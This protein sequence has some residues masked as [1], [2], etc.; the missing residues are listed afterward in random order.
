MDVNP[1]DASN[2]LVTTPLKK[3]TYELVDLPTM[4]KDLSL[5]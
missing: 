1:T 4:H 5:E 2:V 3:K